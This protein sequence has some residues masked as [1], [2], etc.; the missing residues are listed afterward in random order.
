M[1]DVEKTVLEGDRKNAVLNMLNPK[2][3]VMGEVGNV[4]DNLGK[5]YPMATTAALSA[6]V[7]GLSGY[8]A[9]MTEVID[10]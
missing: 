6:A 8:A 7:G 10:I 2:E 1:I 3:R 5:K 9:G 4:I